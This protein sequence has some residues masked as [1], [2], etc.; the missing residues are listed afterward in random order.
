LY[1]TGY[2][3]TRRRWCCMEHDLEFVLTALKECNEDVIWSI[4]NEILSYDETPDEYVDYYVRIIESPEFLDSD[5]SLT[6]LV[7]LFAGKIDLCFNDEQL[8]KFVMPLINVFNQVEDLAVCSAIAEYIGKFFC[9]E[10]SLAF[11]AELRNVQSPNHR[12]MVAEGYRLFI[13]D[14]QNSDALK[15][16]A[17]DELLEMSKD[18]NTTVRAEALHAVVS[19]E[20]YIQHIINPEVIIQARG[21]LEQ[22]IHK[23]RQG[24]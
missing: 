2:P 19:C 4:T 17:F 23:Y 9:D 18:K 3:V 6:F 11:I 5:C 20:E 21:E 15:F 13:I 24:M 7:D 14:C 16:M 10:R 1:I 8:N 12:A 22:I